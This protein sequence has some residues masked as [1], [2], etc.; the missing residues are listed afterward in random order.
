MRR[1][2]SHV[3]A[4]GYDSQHRPVS[5]KSDEEA[6]GDDADLSD[7]YFSDRDVDASK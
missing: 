1:L 5:D 2:P 4:D 6:D 3:D 7:G